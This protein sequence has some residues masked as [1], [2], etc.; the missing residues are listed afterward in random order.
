MEV[1]IGSILKEMRI[2]SNWTL[3]R[4]CIANRLDPIRYSMIERDIM[5]PNIEE[6]NLYLDLVEKEKEVSMGDRER[7]IVYHLSRAIINKQKNL[8]DIVWDEHY[9]F[10]LLED[11]FKGYEVH[12][13]PK[14]AS[15]RR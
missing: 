3:R 4:F 12:L 1:T 14:S 11:Y 5:K 8:I 2:R 9:L 13:V 15:K 10:K 7:D 6:L